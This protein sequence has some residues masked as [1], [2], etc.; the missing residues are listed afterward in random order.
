MMEWRT[1]C[2]FS[3]WCTTESWQEHL[4]LLLFMLIKLHDAPWLKGTFRPILGWLA[5]VGCRMQVLGRLTSDYERVSVIWNFSHM[6][7]PHF[8]RNI[9]LLMWWVRGSTRMSRGNCQLQ[10][11]VSITIYGPRVVLHTDMHWNMLHSFSS[12][13]MS[14]CTALCLFSIW[15]LVAL[16]DLSSDLLLRTHVLLLGDCFCSGV[17]KIINNKVSISLEK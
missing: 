10:Q 15:P 17:S 3:S 1:T 9:S 12:A 5:E 16:S 8:L 13:C 7:V 4:M 14:C 2:V 11:R 6:S